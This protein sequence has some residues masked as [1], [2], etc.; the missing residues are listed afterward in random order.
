MVLLVQSHLTHLLRLPVLLRLYRPL[1]QLH[2]LPRLVL[3]HPLPHLYHWFRS[4]LLVL[5]RPLPLLPLLRRL[6]L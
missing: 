5:L 2:P 6:L 1:V 4:F 3:L